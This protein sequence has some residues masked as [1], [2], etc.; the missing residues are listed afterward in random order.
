MVD[1]PEPA[2]LQGGGQGG[3]PHQVHLRPL[4]PCGFPASFPLSSFSTGSGQ[5]QGRI[6]GLLA[7]S[8][9]E[10]GGR[11]PEE[12]GGIGEGGGETTLLLPLKFVVVPS[13]MSSQSFSPD[14]IDNC[15]F[16]ANLAILKQKRLKERR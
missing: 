3:R 16:D 13:H 14:D 11:V 5:S 1:Q 8:G 9:Q 2:R 7:N 4:Q 10:T 15:I 6:S 12:S